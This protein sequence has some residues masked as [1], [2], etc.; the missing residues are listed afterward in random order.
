MTL[1]LKQRASIYEALSPVLGEEN[2]EAM[3]AELPGREGDELV[4][5]DFL[6]AELS[7]EIGGLRSELGS[8]I[9]G[10]RTEMH[11]M[12]HDQTRWFVSVMIAV[13]TVYSG[14]MLAAMKLIS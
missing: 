10:L 14:L 7:R 12:F 3:L 11:T 9:S 2:A 8:E 1:T 5:K 6:R 13:L 4:T